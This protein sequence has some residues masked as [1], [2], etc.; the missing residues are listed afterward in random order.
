MI[1]QEE[2]SIFFHNVYSI[3]KKNNILIG[4]VDNNDN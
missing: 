3:V 4:Y 2:T 1:Y